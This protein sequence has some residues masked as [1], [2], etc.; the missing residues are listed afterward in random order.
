MQ[1]ARQLTLPSSLALTDLSVT[2]QRGARDRNHLVLTYTIRA[3]AQTIVKPSV[4]RMRRKEMRF[5]LG[6]SLDARI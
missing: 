3:R 5:L 1:A 4:N 2:T 6:A